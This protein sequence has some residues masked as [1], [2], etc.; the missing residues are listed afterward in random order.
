LLH[1]SSLSV[2][3]TLSFCSVLAYIGRDLTSKP[4]VIMTKCVYLDFLSSSA[5]LQQSVFF[6]LSETSWNKVYSNSYGLYEL[7]GK[8]GEPKII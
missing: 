1:G 6:S 4:V 7:Y 2:Y 3:R 8:S 5:A